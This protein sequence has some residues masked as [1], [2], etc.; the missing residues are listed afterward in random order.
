MNPFHLR[1]PDFSTHP[2]PLCPYG[3]NRHNGETGRDKGELERI[4]RNINVGLTGFLI[5]GRGFDVFLP[6][7]GIP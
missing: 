3:N 1:G 4:L 7:R 6:F 2:R 5:R